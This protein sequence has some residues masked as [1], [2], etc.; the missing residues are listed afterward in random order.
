MVGWYPRDNCQIPSLC[1][2]NQIL[3][4]RA[5]PERKHFIFYL[6]KSR[7]CCTVLHHSRVLHFR[8]YAV[9]ASEEEAGG[10]NS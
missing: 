2:H 9:I 6:H 1:V 5:S 7:I 4:S 3:T 8:I 10:C